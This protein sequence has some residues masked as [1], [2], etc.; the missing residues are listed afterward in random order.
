M[1]ERRLGGRDDYGGGWLEGS[2]AG[3]ARGG[4][5]G[6]ERVGEAQAAG[7]PRRGGAKLACGGGR[8]DTAADGALAEG[9]GCNDLI[10]TRRGVMTAQIGGFKIRQE[11][12]DSPE[13]HTTV[14]AVLG[15]S[16]TAPAG[17]GRT[18]QSQRE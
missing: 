16:G 1:E 6:L 8:Q 18:R 7:N 10:R 15:R 4:A 17:V 2:V 14:V 9:Y 11:I 5:G 13:I 12:G 3:E